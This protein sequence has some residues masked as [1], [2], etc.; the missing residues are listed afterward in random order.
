MTSAEAEI[1]FAF[2]SFFAAAS[3]GDAV[4]VDALV[5][6]ALLLFKVGRV[7]H[8]T[9]M[10][11][12]VADF[13]IRACSAHYEFDDVRIRV[14]GRLATVTCRTRAEIRCPGEPSRVASWL[15]SAILERTDRWRIVFYHST[16]ETSPFHEAP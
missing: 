4:A 7:L 14:D 2:R 12:A 15:E 10:L 11:A 9:D 1:D 8:R 3:S 6:P 16:D 5:D 13:A